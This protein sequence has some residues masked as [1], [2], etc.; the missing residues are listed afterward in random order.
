MMY[1]RITIVMNCLLLFV[2]CTF[3][4][5]ENIQ[6]N[7]E[8]SLLVLTF[9]LHGWEIEWPTRLGMILDKV[10]ELK[11]DLIGFQE[12]LQTPGTGG[13]DN[14]VRVMVDSLYRRTGV[15][16]EYIFE[17]THTGWGRYDEGL[18]ILSRHIILERGILALP[19]G[20]FQRKALYCK[21]LTPVGVVHFFDTHLSHLQQNEP[22]RIAQVK[23]IKKFVEI[24]SADGIPAANIV[25]G[26]FNAIPSSRPILKLTQVDSAGVR[27]LDSWAEMNPGRSGFTVPAESPNARIDYIFLRDGDKSRVTGSQLVLE[28]PN[29]HG[30]YPSDHIGVFSTFETML[31]I[32]NIEI[33]TPSSGDQLSGQATISWSCDVQLQFLTITIFVSN[34]AGRTW[35]ELWTGQSEK[36]T[37]LWN[38]LTMSDGTRYMLRVVASNDSSFGFTQSIGTFIVNNPG[39]APPEIELKDPR[40]GE[41]LHDE[42]E[43]KW[44]AADADGD[45]LLISLDAS[46]D[47][48]STWMSLVM[49]EANDGS[50]VWNTRGMPNSPFFRIRLRGTDGSIESADTSGLFTVENERT[51]LPVSNF[52]HIEGDGSGTI[53]GNV[54]DSSKLTG[55]VYR[56]VFDDTLSQ[57]KTYNVLDLDAGSFVVK[58]AIEMDGVTEGPAF[59]GVRLVIFDYPQAA[60]DPTLTGWVVGKTDLDHSISLPELNSGTDIIKGYPYPADYRLNFHDHLVDTSSSFLGAIPIP[61]YFDMWNITEDRQVEVVFVE[62]DQNGEISPHDQVY[63]IEKNKQGE[64]M[65]SWM[66]VFSGSQV[67]RPPQP[68]DEFLLA[69]LKPFTHRDVFEFTTAS[70]VN[71]GDVNGDDVTN[72]LDVVVIVRH[73]LEIELIIG[74]DFWRADYNADGQVNGLDVVGIVN[75]IL[76]IGECTPP[77][78][79][80]MNDLQR[81]GPRNEMSDTDCISILN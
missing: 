66:I 71:V 29:E 79:F 9:N 1:S 77:T 12:V 35:Q 74:S 45:L 73:V 72:I 68:G 31:Q 5:G 30:I 3:C 48:G 7:R 80:D 76:G 39:N 56:V 54:V 38:T 81:L 78:F 8:N 60:I 47:D 25:C 70:C 64:L 62:L 14:S 4:L 13:I 65:L 42:H 59:G 61:I 21:A 18:G 26:D 19:A 33:L 40:G 41:L 17:R 69:T 55:H 50:Y 34:D 37:Y 43:I 67:Y 6:E 53:G 22:V 20:V 23:A 16:Y 49:D 36:N 63:I 58:D 11:P 27:Y 51:I 32:L 57:Q 15:R 75:V 52:R 28:K 46:I 10:E 44:T 2:L 24:K